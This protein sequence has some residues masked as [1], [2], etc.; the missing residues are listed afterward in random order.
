MVEPTM[1]P[2][3]DRLELRIPPL[4]LVLIFAAVM[5]LVS[6]YAPSL[7]IAISWRPTLVAALVGAGAAFAVAG[8]VAFRKAKTTVDPTKPEAAST[9]VV[10]GVYRVSRNPMYVGFLLVLAGWAVFLG[11]GLPFLLLPLFVAY[12][13]RFQI[14][15][16]ERALAARFGSEYASYAQSVRRWL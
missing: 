5:W 11:H 6:T 1:S 7:A 8:V 13:N 16:E 10:S 2:G 9:M 3:A 12:L 14:R 15:P 4:A